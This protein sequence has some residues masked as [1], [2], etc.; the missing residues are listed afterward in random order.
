MPFHLMLILVFLA[1]TAMV[2]IL[3]NVLS[4]RYDPVSE[5]LRHVR[6][7]SGSLAEQLLTLNDSEKR[8]LDPRLIQLLGE[9]AQYVRKDEPGTRKHLMQ[10]GYYREN[11]VR[12]YMGL[13]VFLAIVLFVLVAMMGLTRNPG[14][15]SLAFSMGAAA[16]GYIIPSFYLGM[17][18]RK[19][20]DAIN[21]GLPDALD[22]LV[23]CVEAGLGLNSA[24]VRVGK[25]MSERYPEMSE[26]FLLVNQEMRTG[27]SREQ[28]LH[29]LADRNRSKHLRILVSA[30]VLSDRLGTNIADTLRA[31]SD[32]LRTQ[33]RQQAEE[34]AAKAGIKMLFP[35]VFFILPTLFIV[36]L[37]P[38]VILMIQEV[39]PVINK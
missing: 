16:T 2:F 6:D 33:F 8:K 1:V 38:A 32:S 25:E 11:G 29:N 21:S 23:V 17:K 18:I 20:Q 13:K 19:R 12:V 24:L 3:F 27:L 10:A 36:I 22:F 31:Q 30:V 4:R 14:L 39:F 35:L 34:Q 37:G 15:T 26:E 28:A 9:L 5:R 7:S